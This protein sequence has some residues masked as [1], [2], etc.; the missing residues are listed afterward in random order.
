MRHTRLFAGI[1][2][3]LLLT[4]FAAP[5]VPVWHP[6][7]RTTYTA[8][9]DS[10]GSEP[11]NLDEIQCPIPMKDRVRNYTGIQCVYSSLEMIGRWAEEPKLMN[12]PLTSRAEC[13][14]YSGPQRAAQVLNNLGVKF[15]NVYRDRAAGIRLIKKAM[16]E[17]R[18]ALFGVPGHAMVIVH[19][20]ESKDVVKYVDNSDR[21]LRIQTMTVRRFK[22]RWDGWVIVVY[23]DND[24]IP[25][26]TGNLA[27]KIPIK[28]RNNPQGTYPKNYIP[29][30]R[31]TH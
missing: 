24:I 28:D 5:P 25:F 6:E 12:P 2:A 14:G 4:G 22:Q 1:I 21:R 10:K 8:P 26:K 7:Y 18:G 29:M 16:A 27:N 3:L 23:A 19:Y 17:H 31:Q 11:E 30:P 9:Y 15:E 20:D 13:K